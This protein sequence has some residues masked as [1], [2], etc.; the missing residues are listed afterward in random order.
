MKRI[1]A[2]ILIAA[3]TIGLF[4]G[5]QQ[6]A[7][8][9]ST[10]F[11]AM[12][13]L[14][15]ITAYGEQAQESVESAEK[16]I[17]NLENL[18][19]S[20]KKNS[21]IYQLNE[22][23]SMMVSDDVYKILK[24]AVEASQ[25]TGGKFDAT[26][27]SISD[28]WQIG[29]DDAHVPKQ[30]EIDEALKSVDYHNIV[31]G[32]NNQVTLKNNAKIDLGGIGKGYAADQVVKILK[33][34]NID[35]ALIALAGNIY[36]IGAKN[37]NSGWVVGVANPDNSA[38]SLVSLELEDESIVT[39]GD[40]ERYFEKD[41]IIYH[42][43]MDSKTGYPAKSDLRSATVLMKDSTK[44]DAYAT[45]LY[46]M[47]KDTAMKFCEDHGIEAIFVTKDKKIYATDG[48]HDRIKFLGKGTGYTYE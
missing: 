7:N 46:I 44:A 10:E 14:M 35:Q 21:E 40:Y 15:S 5:C 19:S 26:I 20:T 28:L 13:T 39:S 2:L 30:S 8:S 31:L 47:G 48:I 24:N 25:E 45:A 3:S 38:D 11:F 17:N 9:Y 36:V 22:K 27:E 34:Y 6:E 42:H 37:E 41:G 12:D 4:C 43:I 1:L 33:S 23:K 16:Y 29:T 32:D 18:I